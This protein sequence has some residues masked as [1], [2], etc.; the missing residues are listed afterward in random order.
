MGE[1]DGTERRRPHAPDPDPATVIIEQAVA[2]V[3]NHVPPLA[4]EVVVRETLW[5]VASLVACLLTLTLLFFHH[6]RLR[7]SEAQLDRFA[8]YVVETTK[9]DP[10][11]GPPTVEQRTDLLEQC[12]FITVPGGRP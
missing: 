9:L 8:C 3:A 1:W 11:A 4:P 10:A 5:R 12:E 7:D 2:R 6:A